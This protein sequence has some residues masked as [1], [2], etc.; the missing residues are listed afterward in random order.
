MR[1]DDR[2]QRRSGRQKL[3]RRA[4]AL[5]VSCAI[6]WLAACGD[7][8]PKASAPVDVLV[9]AVIEQDVPIYGEWIGT[10]GGY[11]DAQ[12][13]PRVQGYLFSQNYKEGTLVKKGDLLFVIDPRPFEATLAQS[14]AEQIKAEAAQKQS[15]IIADRYTPLAKE[16]VI[17]QQEYDNAV[18]QNLANVAAVQAARANVQQASLNLGYTRVISPIDG[19][20]G[21]RQS[22][23]GDLVGPSQGKV[24]TTVSQVNPIY[25]VFTI[26]EQEYLRSAKIFSQLTDAQGKDTDAH[27]DLYLSNES[28]YPERGTFSFADREVNVTTGTIKLKASFANPGNVLRP[29]QYARVRAVV[30]EK[31]HALLVPQRAVQELQGSYQVAVVGA[32]NK[33]TWRSIKAGERQ[34][35]LWIIDE[36]LNASDRVIVEGHQK[37]KNGTIVSPKPYEPTPAGAPATPAQ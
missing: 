7:D 32:D 17:S 16:G 4:S 36:G 2:G 33:A 19:I 25:A 22:N 21:I 35:Q 24:L 30:S 5:G 8:A 29:G 34:G 20:A 13:V 10:L 6:A 26:S 3:V 12:I 11:I 37:V 31:K 18:Q 14:R 28:L 27:I 9:T 1:A 15:Q 23:I